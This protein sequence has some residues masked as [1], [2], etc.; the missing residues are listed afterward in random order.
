MGKILDSQMHSL[1]HREG[2]K[3]SRSILFVHLCPSNHVLTVERNQP[4][5]AYLTCL[6]AWQ[7]DES[8]LYLPANPEERGEIK[9]F[10]YNNMS[11]Q[12]VEARIEL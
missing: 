3:T 12:A 7:F 5:A 8:L 10:I 11:K 2:P 1:T 6:N 4:N 9:T